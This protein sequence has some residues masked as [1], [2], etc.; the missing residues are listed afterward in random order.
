MLQT[1]RPR[2]EPPAAQFEG[3]KLTVSQG[4]RVLCELDHPIVERMAELWERNAADPSLRTSYN[5]FSAVLYVCGRNPDLKPVMSMPESGERMGVTE[6]C[7][8]LQ[9]PSQLQICGSYEAPGELPDTWVPCRG[10][11]HSAIIVGADR[12]EGEMYLFEKDSWSGELRIAKLSDVI[13]Y[14]F[15]RRGCGAEYLKYG[16]LP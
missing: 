11:L 3:T 7:N 10:P 13:S 14:Y 16:E 2:I 4:G 12:D 1:A 6:A 9:P 15:N 5:C 8:R